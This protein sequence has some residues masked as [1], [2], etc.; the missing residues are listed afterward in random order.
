MFHDFP[1][2]RRPR[3]HNRNQNHGFRVT[4]MESL[5]H[6]R[7]LTSLTFQ[8]PQHTPL[9]NPMQWQILADLD[10]DGQSDFI[11]ASKGTRA[12]IRVGLVG[13]GGEVDLRRS[14]TIAEVTAGVTGDI[15]GDGNTD[16]IV[17]SGD[18]LLVIV[19]EGTN[20][21]GWAGFSEPQE[22]PPQ[23]NF[24]ALTLGDVDRD[25]SPDL[26]AATS[27]DVMVLSNA[28][29]GSF[30]P[31]VTYPLQQGIVD[32]EVN[33]FNGDGF[34]DIAVAN[35]ATHGVD[36]LMNLGDGAFEQLPAS[37]NLGGDGVISGDFDANGTIDLVVIA[38]DQFD[39]NVH[40][41]S[42]NGDGT[43]EAVGLSHFVIGQAHS[44]DAA[45]MN[46][47]GRQDLIVGH[48][49]TFHHPIYG[50]SAGGVSVLLSS[51]AQVFLAPIKIE[52]S[53]GNFSLGDI[54][55]DGRADMSSMG[56]HQGSGHGI[57]FTRASTYQPFDL[58][59]TLPAGRDPA[60]ITIHDLNVDGQDD[61]VVTNQGSSDVSVYLADDV[62]FGDE[63]RF[64][65]VSR[66][67]A[68]FP[69]NFFNGD[70]PDLA[71]VGAEDVGLLRS[72]GDGSFEEEVRYD[73][74]Q[75][76]SGQAIADFN[77]DGQPD[78]FVANRG[79]NDVSVLVGSADGSFMETQRLPV[80]EEPRA[81][82]VEDWNGD[83]Y[84]D[85]A[86][87][88][89][90]SNDVSLLMGGEDQFAP[91][92]RYLVGRTPT[93]LAA[94][95][96][97]GNGSLDLA[98]GNQWTHD[99][100]FLFN[101]GGGHFETVNEFGVGENPT[102][103]TSGD[104]NAD[105][106]QDLIVTNSSYYDGNTREISVLIGDGVGGFLDRKSYPLSTMPFATDVADFDGD[107]HLDVMVM[108][109][110]GLTVMSGDG[111]G[112]LVNATTHPVQ[113]NF[114]VNDLRVVDLNADGNLDVVMT[115]S[116][117]HVMWGNEDG[118]FD[119]PQ[120]IAGTSSGTSDV[121]INDFNGDGKLDLAAAG[122][123]CT[124]EC[125]S[126]VYVSLAE[127]DSF[128]TSFLRVSNANTDT[129]AMGDTNG[130]GHADLHFTSQRRLITL[131]GNGDGT[132]QDGVSTSVRGNIQSI[133]TFDTNADGVD[134]VVLSTDQSDVQIYLGSESDGFSL[135]DQ[136]GVRSGATQIA[137]TDTDQNGT[138]DMVLFNA[139]IAR[140]LLVEGAGDGTYVAP[141]GFHWDA[142][143]PPHSVQVADIN[144]DA[145]LDL[146]VASRRSTEILLFD[147]EG[148]FTATTV[149]TAD[150]N[151]DLGDF[152]GDGNVDIVQ[153][154]GNGLY[155]RFGDGTGS[156]ARPFLRGLPTAG[157]YLVAAADVNHDGNLDVI[158]GLEST[159]HILMGRGAEGLERPVTY[160]AG[161]GIS[162]IEAVD[163][164]HDGAMDVLISN[165]PL[166]RRLRAPQ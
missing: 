143:N 57:F 50:N 133:S 88:N 66:P 35:Q 86:T 32:L 63:Q 19:N 4:S 29:D 166:G 62:G 46:G 12:A 112:N 127:D 2:L 9:P 132:F 36:L 113:D 125:I 70:H 122:W 161:A 24:N 17:A 138:A 142:N 31:A 139:N 156:F 51:T 148:Q 38:A 152:D 49:G 54:D 102:G 101:R 136:F 71:V 34:L 96:L 72:L 97:D 150:G 121:Q 98:V 124:G 1:T 81:I 44:I 39:D 107:G 117:I 144:N 60:A 75:N 79:S 30:A 155:L 123:Q 80:G 99:V 89:S 40:L 137:F 118:S 134:D 6:R 15:D 93:S 33:D 109:S 116:D 147:M 130:D 115:Q 100:D 18:R 16:F 131:A 159:I 94:L 105:G 126:G 48:Y 158:L 76:P 84:F 106:I 59:E 3:K 154:Q 64:N 73:T 43:F 13:D 149:R 92:K 52:G 58:L 14:H 42:G 26:I 164:N 91:A 20:D 129:M 25:G 61:I 69:G 165:A 163:V 140:V 114:Y 104:L 56:Y 108:E 55:G 23:T 160:L 74:G 77:G 47:D 53:D 37:S 27:S 68:A 67:V 157:D 153:Q 111:Q 21:D 83:G 82:L 10:N 45:D 162:S 11:A 41:L 141:P 119:R 145:T 151:F 87:A 65:A 110:N 103:F 22:L 128:S 95:D 78:L 7:L 135:A 85:I 120:V 90:Q 5:E 28:G 146:V 8:T